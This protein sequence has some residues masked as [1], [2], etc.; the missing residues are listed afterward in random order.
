MNSRD[1]I[2]FKIAEALLVDYTSVYYVD[3]VTNAYQWYSNDP[4]YHSL[5]IEKG[6]DDFFKNLK[7]DADKVV[8]EEDKHIFME[9]MQKE[10]LISEM[11]RGM[12]QSVEYRL[13][14]DGKPVYHRLR[15][16]RSVGDED[17]YFIL[18]IIN[19][20]KE[21]RERQEAERIEKE[22]EIFNDIAMSLAEHFDSI[23][24]VEVDT[25]S[26]FEIS[27]KNAYKD[28]KVPTKGVDF[29][30]ETAE[31]I[32]LYIYRE[33][34]EKVA[35][36]FEKEEMLKNLSNRKSYAITYRLMMDGEP[37]HIRNT[38][39][40]AEDHKHIIVGLENID[41]EV[42]RERN[43]AKA[44]HA[45]NALARK[46]AL[47]GVKNKTAYREL[48][49]TVQENLDKG[50]DYLPFAM[51]ICDLNDLKVIND[52][53]GHKIGDEFIVKACTLIC[54][55]FSHSP[56]FRIG[57]DEFLVFLSERDRSD[58]EILVN[59]FKEIILEN[60]K[61]KEGP[62]VAI[63][64]ASFEQGSDTSVTE[65][66]ERAD[67]EMYINKKSLKEDK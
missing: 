1:D 10:H 66:F 50:V 23:Y 54:D 37:V 2:F 42:E 26:F 29:F 63:G 60:K 18:G 19:V 6:G 56:V 7:I 43:Q 14:I 62:I 8:Y 64:L 57:G 30:K 40:W 3:A 12:M 67:K 15:V 31:N 48:E 53:Y 11:K 22:R 13:V 49:K 16:I 46:D 4:D 36:A 58:K 27:S 47:T 32:K 41:D 25:G 55:T 28:L 35:K 59:K 5:Q 65:V 9:D 61:K 51:A 21:V 33:D 38:Q 20:D 24:Y 39:I 44:L 17:D 52:T 34:R 45:A